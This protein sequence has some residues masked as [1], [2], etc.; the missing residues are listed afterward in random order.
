MLRDFSPDI[1][2]S[3]HSLPSFDSFHALAV[4]KRKGAG[5]FLSY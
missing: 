2:L 1:V 4:F 3:D 5:L